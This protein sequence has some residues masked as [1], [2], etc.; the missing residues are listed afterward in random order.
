MGE[1]WGKV[2]CLSMGAARARKA[3]VI[4]VQGGR[5]KVGTCDAYAYAKLMYTHCLRILYA[6]LAR[7]PCHASHR[8]AV[9]AEHEGLAALLEVE[10]AHD[11]VR[12][13]SGEVPRAGT[14]C[15]REDG[16]SGTRG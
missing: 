6:H 3:L 15:Q 1:V 13:R 2:G 12:S 9:T 8:R 10:D 14:P 11:R 5:C 4:F 16:D 7:A